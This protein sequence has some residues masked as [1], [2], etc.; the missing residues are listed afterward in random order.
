MP[1]QVAAILKIAGGSVLAP[2]AFRLLGEVPARERAKR[3]GLQYA[4]A[5]ALVLPLALAWGGPLFYSEAWKI[6]L[7]GAVTSLGV[8]FQWRA[9][10]LSLSRSAVFI[11]L[12][13]VIPL[14]LSA[15]LLGEWRSFSANLLLLLGFFLAI[16]GLALHVSHDVRQRRKAE[17]AQPPP[18][19]FYANAAA[20]TLI[21]GLATFL[22]NHWAKAGVP[23]SEFLV[24]WYGGALAG[25][26]VLLVVTPATAPAVPAPMPATTKHA[27]I[28]LAGFSIVLNMA[29][30][31]LALQRAPQTVVLPVFAVADIVGPVLVGCL[32]CREWA[33]LHRLAWLYLGVALAGALIMALAHA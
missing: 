8:L 17:A 10:A 6:A 27:L 23:A 3:I 12:S 30:E 21:F 5:V 19:A 11:P 2:L 28:A 9:Y 26:A 31:Y 24:C 18:R 25:A 16:L 20:F 13:N 22:L 29:M 14:I 33:K 4:W 15:A 1:W 32:A 7:L